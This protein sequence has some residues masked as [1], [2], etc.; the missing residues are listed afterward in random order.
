MKKTAFIIED[1]NEFIKR[2]LSDL[3]NKKLTGVKISTM[4]LF[5]EDKTLM[6]N[7]LSAMSNA[8]QKSPGNFLVYYDQTYTRRMLVMPDG[9]YIFNRSLWDFSK[10][11]LKGPASIIRDQNLQEFADTLTNLPPRFYQIETAAGLWKRLVNRPL[12]QHLA[13]SHVKASVIRSSNGQVE[14]AVQTGELSSA[15]KQNN[16]SLSIL[17]NEKAAKFAENAINPKT[18]IGNCGYAIKQIAPNIKLVIDY[19]NYDQPGR[20]SYIHELA[21]TIINPGYISCV[22]GNKPPK[23]TPSNI[24]LVSQYL[25]SGRILKALKLAANPKNHNARVVVPLEPINDYRRSEMGFKLMEKHFQIHRGKNILTPTRSV[26]SHSKCL[27]VAYDD[28]RLSMIFGSD[29]FDSTS[30]TFYRNTELSL[31]IEPVKKGENGYDMIISMLKKLVEAKEID[32][33]EYDRIII[34]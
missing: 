31:F 7:F 26:P 22:V 1:Y 6:H 18:K 30:D 20:I 3:N 16:L 23:Y 28:G 21:E 17:N 24:I 14:A 4:N 32:Q 11:Y 13:T 15:S 19:G 5:A 34:Q 25:P 29:N 27:V 8:N 9:H 12:L 10:K 33:A 2:T